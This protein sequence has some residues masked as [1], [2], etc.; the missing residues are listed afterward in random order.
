[1]ETSQA[2]RIMGRLNTYFLTHMYSEENKGMTVLNVFSTTD[3]NKAAYYCQGKST[4]FFPAN[5]PNISC[6]WT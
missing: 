3:E 1:M 4:L 2:K 5:L 6:S